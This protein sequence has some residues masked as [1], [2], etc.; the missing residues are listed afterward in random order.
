VGDIRLIVNADDFGASE[1]VNE[2]VIRGFREG[3]LT[4]CSLIV[5]GQ[6]FAQAIQ[7]A[8][9]NPHLAVGI[10]LVAVSGR[11]VLTPSEIPSLVD[12]QGCFSNQPVVAG[13]KYYFL[14]QARQE[15]KKELAAQFEKF[16][17]SG[18]RCSHIDGHWHFHIHPVVFDLAIRLGKQYGVCQMRVPEDDVALALRFDPS[19][20]L[21][22]RLYGMIFQVLC[23]QMRRRLAREGF[24]CTD[25]V[26]GFFETGRMNSA[27]FL[28]LLEHLRSETNEIYLH[29][30]Y[31]RIDPTQA[32]PSNRNLAEYQALVDEQVIRRMK[33]LGI[34]L[35]TYEA[36]SPQS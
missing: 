27:Y 28:W 26:Y 21:Q 13:M 4:S 15:L 14:S 12:R 29:P 22:K 6:A 1:E 17:T 9:E 7:L 25:K 8:G 34:H 35:T 32:V 36:L 18:L 11:S 10:H 31:H 3:I 23:R 5:T 30:A 2:A 16:H 33:Q 24:T 20:S 19:R